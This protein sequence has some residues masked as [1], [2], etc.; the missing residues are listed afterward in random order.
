MD[1][2]PSEPFDVRGELVRVGWSKTASSGPLEWCA[3]PDKDASSSSIS[4]PTLSTESSR[5]CGDEGKLVSMSP[6]G[7]R[8]W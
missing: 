5:A 6:T 4:R 3:E 7:W 8:L 2:S 1:I